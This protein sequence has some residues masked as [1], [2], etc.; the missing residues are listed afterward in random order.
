MAGAG[1][2]THVLYG[3]FAGGTG[4]RRALALSAGVI[5][6]AQGGARLSQR[7]RGRYIEWML[8]VALVGLAVRLLAGV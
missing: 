5:V 2:L 4:I 7:I 6:G 8:A 3:S 1:S